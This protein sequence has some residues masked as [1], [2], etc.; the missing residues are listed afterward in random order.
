[1]KI[2]LR[3]VF[4]QFFLLFVGGAVGFILNAEYIGWKSVI[5]E[6]SVQNIFFPVEY[7]D[8]VEDLVLNVGRL[9]L[10]I[11]LNGNPYDS[12]GIKLLDE[13]V[14]NEEVYVALYEYTNAEGTIRR[15][16]STRVRWKSWEYYYEYHGP[17]GADIDEL[18]APVPPGPESAP[19]PTHP[20]APAQ[21][22]PHHPH[23]DEKGRPVP[24]PVHIP[25]N[26]STKPWWDRR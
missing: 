12:T 18:L 24:G 19:V 9:R 13:F 8:E 16:Y 25:N 4:Y 22:A 7:S 2:F 6:R 21:Q 23:R 10:N 5:I 3:T 20:A 1:M 15:D 11:A 14:W 17:E 26:P